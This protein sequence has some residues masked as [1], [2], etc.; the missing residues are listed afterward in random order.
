[1]TDS[2]F[3]ELSTYHLT[4]AVVGV[5]VIMA[6]W[7]PRLVSS[8]EPAAAPLMILFGALAVLIVPGLPALPDPRN[9]PVLWEVI[10]EITVIGA[11]RRG[12]AGG[13]HWTAA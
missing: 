9:A 5:I 8:R 3:F 2:S 13:Q 7:F 11:L 1:M 10:A 4:L 12:N 6:R